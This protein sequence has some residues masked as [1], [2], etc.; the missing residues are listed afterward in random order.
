IRMFTDPETDAER[1]AQADP[2]LG[3]LGGL[4]DLPAGWRA[5]SQLVLQPAPDSWCNEYLRL[6]V[7]HPLAPERIQR[8]SDTALPGLALLAALLGIVALALQVYQWYRAGQWLALVGLLATVGVA[9]GFGL[10]LARKLL[11]R[12][13]YDMELVREKV[14]RVAYRYE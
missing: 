5:L 12:P 2:V 10:P 1:S 4:S 6:T 7:Q 3:I 8:P 13:I 11:A 14:S 9:L